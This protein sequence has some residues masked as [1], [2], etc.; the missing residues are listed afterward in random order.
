MKRPGSRKK[1]TNAESIPKPSPKLPERRD[2][3]N[4][5]E[6]KDE[7]KTQGWVFFSGFALVWPES[8]ES[9]K[10]CDHPVSIDIEDKT[11]EKH[12]PPLL[13][14]QFTCKCN[15]ICVFV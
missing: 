2:Y 8:N 5:E 10:E 3:T 15:A 12:I 11:K 13:F 14:S 6:R 7:E 1:Q 4:V 9:C